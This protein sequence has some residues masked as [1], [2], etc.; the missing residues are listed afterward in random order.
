MIAS[1]WM[2]AGGSLTISTGLYRALVARL[3]GDQRRILETATPNSKR[4]THMVV[5]D[6]ALAAR[7]MDDLAISLPAIIDRLM[8]E[9]PRHAGAA[10]T[11]LAVLTDTVEER[12]ERKSTLGLDEVDDTEWPEGRGLTKAELR[13]PMTVI[14]ILKKIARADGR[15]WNDLM[16]EFGGMDRTA[17]AYGL[18]WGEWMTDAYQSELS[19]AAAAI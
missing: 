12:E 4:A 15:S 2:T 19:A 10:S 1:H 11:L 7:L 9:E 5:R 17:C 3:D 14:D 18:P 6:K 16:E 13:D 8:V